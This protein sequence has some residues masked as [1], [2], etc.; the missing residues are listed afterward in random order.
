MDLLTLLK[1]ASDAKAS[2]LHLSVGAVPMI[3]VRGKLE[4]LDKYDILLP[5]EAE[6]IL[7][8]LLDTLARTELNSK[9]QYDMSYKTD[10]AR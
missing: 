9:G 10:F 2:D 6:R 7:L 8:P 1:E 5:E 4:M 3:R